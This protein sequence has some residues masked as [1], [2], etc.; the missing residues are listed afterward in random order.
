MSTQI[1]TYIWET[2]SPPKQVQF[3]INLQNKTNFF[4]A[5]VPQYYFLLTLKL[6]AVIT[7]WKRYETKFIFHSVKNNFLMNFTMARKIN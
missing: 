1:V 7:I 4:A 2:K 5:S 3:G 6:H